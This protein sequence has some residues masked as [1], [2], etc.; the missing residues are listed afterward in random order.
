MSSVPNA[1][2]RLPSTLALAVLEDSVVAAV[3][4]E[5]DIKRSGK[6]A[7]AHT[8]R[9]SL[10]RAQAETLCQALLLASADATADEAPRF[11]LH[12]RRILRQF[13]LPEYTMIKADRILI[14]DLGAGL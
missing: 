5:P 12:R 4:G 9:W 7:T 13:G 6:G 2:V 1:T 14:E 10:S 8:C 3:L 11:H